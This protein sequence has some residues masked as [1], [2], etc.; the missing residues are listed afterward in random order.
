MGRHSGTTRAKRGTANIDG[1]GHSPRPRKRKAAQPSSAPNAGGAPGSGLRGAGTPPTT[2]KPGAGDEVTPRKTTPRRKRPAVPTVSPVH[3]KRLRAMTVKKMV[4]RVEYLRD[5]EGVPYPGGYRRKGCPYRPPQDK[6]RLVEMLNTMELAFRADLYRTRAQDTADASPGGILSDS[7][8]RRYNRPSPLQPAAAEQVPL[9]PPC[10]RGPPRR[11]PH[12]MTTRSV[13]TAG[14][15]SAP[16]TPVPTN[17]PSTSHVGHVN[18]HP[19]V[20]GPRA[21]PMDAAR[22]PGGG[23]GGGCLHE[24]SATEYWV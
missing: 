4:E 17:A 2:G 24:G 11:L 5:V 22:P 14:T 19:S 1:D 18:G 21:L 10:R 8:R 9:P 7:D 12:A 20:L 6:E 15:Q 13:N 23:A 16:A 3:A